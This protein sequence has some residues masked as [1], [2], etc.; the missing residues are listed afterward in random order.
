MRTK[1]Q[2]LLLADDRRK[3]AEARYK[4]AVSA[5][6]KQA[7]AVAIEWKCGGRADHHELND[8]ASCVEV[9]A[10]TKAELRSARAAFTRIFKE[11]G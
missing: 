5:L 10:E 8:L 3:L 2:R 4:R 11:R 7:S 1:T 6:V 9:E